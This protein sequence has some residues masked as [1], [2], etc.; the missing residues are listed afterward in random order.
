MSNS[1]FVGIIVSLCI[2]GII[3]IMSLSIIYE[4]PTEIIAPATATLYHASS[5]RVVEIRGQWPRAEYLRINEWL[6]SANVHVVDIDYD[7][8]SCYIT[9]IN[10]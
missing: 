2:G 8:S 6:D 1:T 3:T 9:Y 5:L 10:P 4:S 7:R